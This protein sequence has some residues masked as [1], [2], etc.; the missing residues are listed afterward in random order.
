MDKYD[1]AVAYL[2]EKPMEIIEAWECPGQYDPG[3]LFQF[4]T[5]DG[6]NHFDNG[7]RCGC[8]TQVRRGANSANCHLTEA[9]RS[10]DRIP[11]VI[12]D[13]TPSHLPI[14][15][16]WQRYLDWA[17]RGVP[18]SEVTF[19]PIVLALAKAA[20]CPVPETKP[21]LPSVVLNSVDG[22]LVFRP[23]SGVPSE[24]IAK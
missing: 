13:V 10:D 15:A 1:E 14:F 18:A 22:S 20:G 11:T 3:V 24:L 16:A 8:L 7:I 9:I 21:A 17:I 12:D 2:T 4:T 19:C 5:S 23:L 6:M